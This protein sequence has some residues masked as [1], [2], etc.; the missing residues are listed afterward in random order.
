MGAVDVE[1]CYARPG[2]ACAV[3]V[4]V[5]EGTTVRAAIEQSG[6]LEACPD[7]DLQRAGIGIF[8]RACEPGQVVRPGDRIEIYRAL[9]SS[10][11]E[12]RRRA[13]RRR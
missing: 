10:P 13:A 2:Q 8:G 11:V 1:I 7:I 9:P 5:A 6:I 12:M 3:P 4:S